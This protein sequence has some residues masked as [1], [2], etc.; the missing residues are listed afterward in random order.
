[1]RDDLPTSC[2]RRAS[3]TARPN[4]PT[5]GRR[6]TWRARDAAALASPP[7][8]TRSTRAA[9]AVVFPDTPRSPRCGQRRRWS[10]SSRPAA[11]PAVEARAEA[12]AA[13][14]ERR[15]RS[16]AVASGG[17]YS[18]PLVYRNG[19]GMSPDVAA[20]YD[21]MS[22]AAVAARITL[23]VVS[24]FRSDAEQAELFAAHPDPKW[25]APPGKLAPSL[26]DRAGPRPRNRLRL[27]RREREPFRLRPALQLGGLAHGFDRPPAP[28]SD[29]GNSVARRP[30]RRGPPGGATLPLRPARFRATRSTPPRSGTSPPRCSRP[31]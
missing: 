7:A 5:S 13:P 11:R 4:P 22:A 6:P 3:R 25:V 20:A 9:C 15:W 29:A 31:S 21:Q 16:P 18:G 19:E 10:A 26:R 14:L 28:C 30:G 8:T 17:G 27:D 1:M 2:R 12:E 23:I 24:G